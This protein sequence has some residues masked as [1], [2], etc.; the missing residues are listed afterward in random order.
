MRRGISDER[1]TRMRWLRPFVLIAGIAI[2]LSLGALGVYTAYVT[3][4]WYQASA[5]W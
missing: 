4:L 2:A 5:N 1:M 3:R